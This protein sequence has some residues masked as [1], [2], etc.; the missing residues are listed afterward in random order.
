MELIGSVD[1]ILS[2]FG[3]KEVGQLITDSCHTLT[4]NQT[5]HNYHMGQ[6]TTPK[7]PKQEFNIIW[8]CQEMM[9][10]MSMELI[11]SVDVILSDFGLKEVG[12]LVADSCHTLTTNQTQ[13]HSH[14]QDDQPKTIV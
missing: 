13:H 12:Q 1:V 11:G 4:T 14:G 5:Q 3:L 9:V 2:D 7:P 6:M 8:T 10:W